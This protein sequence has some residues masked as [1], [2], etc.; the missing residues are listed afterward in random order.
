M[1]QSCAFQVLA[2][3]LALL[4]AS[5]QG[6]GCDTTKATECVSTWEQFVLDNQNDI[7][8]G[9]VTRPC[10]ALKDMVNCIMDL[11]CCEDFEISQ[12]MNNGINAIS[13]NGGCAG[14]N[15]L[16]NCNF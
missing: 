5:L 7:L 3:F 2:G 16:P 13:N 10:A 9:A 6:C 14:D 8:D 12:S 11:N 15:E 1:K 4:A